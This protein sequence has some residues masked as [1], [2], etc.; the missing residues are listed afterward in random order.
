MAAIRIVSKNNA[1]YISGKAQPSGGLTAAASGDAI[2]IAR[3]D[4][5]EK[6]VRSVYYRDIH[7]EDGTQWGSTAADTV[8]ALN[9]YIQSDNPD[10]IIK[11]TDNIASLTG[12]T[13]SDFQGKPGYTVFVGTS[14]GSLQT[15]NALSLDGANVRL[16]GELV[17]L[18]NTDIK[19]KPGGTGDVEIGNLKFDAD[20][21]VGAGQ[22]G[23][24]LTY[25]NAS[26]AIVLS[27]STGGGSSPWTTTGSDIYYN[28]G[29]VGIGIAAPTE[30]L[31]VVGQLQL[32][33]STAGGNILVNAG[34][35]AITTGT[36]HIAIGN[37]TGQYVISGSSSIAI[38]DG[39]SGGGVGNHI[40]IGKDAGRT[41]SL[42][43]GYGDLVS[44]GRNA[45]R[46][47]A[48]PVSDA[49]AIGYNA[50][51][52]SNGGVHSIAMG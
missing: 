22:D 31:D 40:A 27:T 13:Q 14:D 17:S 35:S 5:N 9:N 11:S 26:G 19:I 52:V 4:N 33:D 3:D 12:V 8:T 36:N 25:D 44:I 38:G 41:S 30:A 10:G 50:M 45:G 1:V 46:G 43:S 42:T 34:T 16:T 21:T 6:I 15:S 32:K 20:Q 51:G 7:K 24:V 48:W 29:N 28:T 18:T 39:A 47:I 23:D 2:T 49:I 37:G